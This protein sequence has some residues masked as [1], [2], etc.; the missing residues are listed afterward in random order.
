MSKYQN[1][2]CI[3]CLKF[4][5]QLNGKD[6]MLLQLPFPYGSLQQNQLKEFYQ[7]PFPFMDLLSYESWQTISLPTKQKGHARK[8]NQTGKTGLKFHLRFY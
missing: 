2:K 8:Q 5:D 3:H 1:P 7:L 6:Y 4:I